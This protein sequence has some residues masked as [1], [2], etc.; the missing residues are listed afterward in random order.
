[1]A[2][3][4]ISGPMGTKE[5]S[6]DP[7]G[8]TLGRDP[9]CDIVL[10]Q[11]SVSRIHARSQNGIFVEG[12]QIRAHAVLPSQQISIRPFTVSLLQEYETKTIPQSHLDV[13]NTVSVFDEGLQEEVVSYGTD[14]RGVLS[15]EL[16][17]QLNEVTGRLL[18]LHSPA[19]LYAEACCYL[20]RLF[21]TLVAFVRLPTRPEPLPNAPEILACH[22]GRHVAEG[23]PFRRPNL[24]LSKRVLDAV[25]STH[26]PVMARS[27]PSSGK[28]LVLTIVDEKTP[29]R[30][31]SAPTG[32]FE[33]TLDVLYLDILEDRSPKEM[34]DF[35]EAVA[36]QINFAQ[37]SLILLEA[38]AE[39][40][41]LDRQL[42]LAQDIQAKMIPQGPEGGFVIDVAVC[43]QPAMW[44]GGDY[45]DVLALE[46]GRIVFA[47]GDV[48]GKGLPAAMIM[49]NLQAALR[50][51]M[52]FCSE[53][54]KVAEY[55]NQHLCQNL[56]DDMFVTLFLGLFD[57]AKNELAYVNAG[58][59]QPVIKQPSANAML[60][61]EPANP[62]LGLFEGPFETFVET[63][64]PNT[65][66]LVVTDGIT[67]ASSPEGELFEMDRLVRLVTDTQADSAE[68]LVQAVTEGTAQFREKLPPHDDITVFALVNRRV[69]MDKQP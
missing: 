37:K 33:G 49:S 35:I 32:D 4:I 25:R 45:Y 18:D 16:I 20:A 39:R 60:L 52:T 8:A 62:P 54:S 13:K 47:V 46:N 41:I 11:S 14:E 59:I 26:R 27:V 19:E 42:A 34:F 9:G 50:T 66:L 36:R 3:L 61:G 69:L 48:S 6:L 64:G 24:H 1:M 56:R 43:Y 53:L 57:P 22:F 31:F 55:L 5:L 21:D 7:K 51:T 30:V 12:Q 40:R 10:D 65:G 67:E 68:G 63:I 2:K 29:H 15:A 28:E 44:V 17:H 23:T 58:H 38:K